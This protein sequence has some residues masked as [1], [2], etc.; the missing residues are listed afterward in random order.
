MDNMDNIKDLLKAIEDDD[1]DVMVHKFE[2]DAET[3]VDLVMLMVSMAHE[4]GKL[5]AVK[6]VVAREKYSA[7][8]VRTI[9]GVELG[10][11]E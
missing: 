6:R 10:A 4:L 8:V 7:D 1:C 3:E 11:E 5:E 9:L 2:P